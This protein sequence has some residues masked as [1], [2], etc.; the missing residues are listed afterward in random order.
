MVYG[1]AVRVQKYIY[2][3]LIRLPWYE[4]IPW[5]DKNHENKATEINYVIDQRN[6][7]F[8]EINQQNFNALIQSRFFD[9]LVPMW[10]EFL[11]HRQSKWEMSAF[12]MLYVD[13]VEDV[14]LGLLRASH[15]GNQNLHIHAIRGLI[16]W[17]C[18]YDKFNYARCLSPYFAQ[19][20]L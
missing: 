14:I 13:F 1:R 3:A 17:C 15:E 11:E 8:G 10:K 18:A 6:D 2:E 16:P 12:W 9:I 5:V 19:M 7:M 4:F 20:T